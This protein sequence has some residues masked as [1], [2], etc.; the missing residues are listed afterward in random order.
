MP[1]RVSVRP[2]AVAKRTRENA[3]PAGVPGSTIRNLRRQGFVAKTLSTARSWST[4]PDRERAAAWRTR[5]YLPSEFGERTPLR[6]HEAVA[7][8]AAAADRAHGRCR[9]WPAPRPQWAID[10]RLHEDAIRQCLR[11]ARAGQERRP[12]ETT[13]ESR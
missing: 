13:S 9:H 12:A 4:S 11:F 5:N 1:P 10:G 7:I 3:C 6:T 8:P 2:G